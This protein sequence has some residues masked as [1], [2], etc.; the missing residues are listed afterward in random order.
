MSHAKRRD[1]SRDCVILRALS[2]LA[3]FVEFPG[4]FD[5]LRLNPSRNE[6]IVSGAIM[7]GC[8]LYSGSKW[9]CT[10]SSSVNHLPSII[11]ITPLCN[12]VWSVSC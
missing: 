6:P 12:F 7:V 1:G 4:P 9:T 11:G 5:V 10:P 2:R 8:A 3:L